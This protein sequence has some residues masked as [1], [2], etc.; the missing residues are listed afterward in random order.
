MDTTRQAHGN[1]ETTPN[2]MC[3]SV[4]WSIGMF[5]IRVLHNTAKIFKSVRAFLIICSYPK[6]I[7]FLGNFS[8]LHKRNVYPKTLTIGKY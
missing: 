7:R 1:A 4:F 2:S 8:I 3:P 5:P 6:F